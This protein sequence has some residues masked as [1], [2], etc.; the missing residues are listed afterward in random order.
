M[1][2]EL[3]P[4]KEGRLRALRAALGQGTLRSAHRMVNALHPAEIALLLESVPPAQRELVWDMVDPEL[5]GEVL[6]E[7]N[8]NV[9]GRLM[10]DM[11]DDE[12]LAVAESMELDDL[13]H[14]VEDLPET[15][16]RQLLRSLDQQDRERLS[17]VLSFPED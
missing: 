7:L 5:E 15:V 2:A 1:N 10:E 17:T 4:E 16:A 6:V 8:E 11:E 14:L 13:A 3:K 9:R 12:L